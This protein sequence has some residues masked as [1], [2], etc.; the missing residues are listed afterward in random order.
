MKAFI[1]KLL[2][3]AKR[4]HTITMLRISAVLTII[5]LALMI[6]SLIQPTPMPVILAMSVG[7]GFGIGAFALYLSVI[8][9]DLRRGRR[10]RRESQQNI[11]FEEKPR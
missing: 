1:K 2:E 8:V 11:V 4:V 10:L 5:G 9:I 7:Q 6:W 3:R